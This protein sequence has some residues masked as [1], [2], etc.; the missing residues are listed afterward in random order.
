ME[1]NPSLKANS[2]LTSQKFPSFYG[3]CVHKN[4]QISRPCVIF[5][6]VLVAPFCSLPAQT[7]LSVNLKVITMGQTQIHTGMMVI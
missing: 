2:G 6:K 1:Q 7:R 4:P 3:T 5:R